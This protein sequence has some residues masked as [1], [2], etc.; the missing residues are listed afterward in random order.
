MESKGDS[1][2]ESSMDPKRLLTRSP[3]IFEEVATSTDDERG[4]TLRAI[5]LG[6]TRPLTA[7]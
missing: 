3:W 4:S 1:E 2:G 5:Y 6:G 7:E